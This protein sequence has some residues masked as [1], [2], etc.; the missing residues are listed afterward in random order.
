MAYLDR[1]KNL[2]VIRIVLDGPPE[3]GKATTLRAL[4]H[5]LRQTG[6][7][8]RQMG[9]RA[10]HVDWL[11]HSSGRTIRLLV[12]RAPRG[13]MRLRHRRV[14]AA[15]VVVYVTPATEA[16]L[17]R[18]LRKLRRMEND[19]AACGGAPPPTIVQ[20]N[21]RDQPD[22]MT[23]E[24]LRHALA[25][26]GLPY[27][28]VETVATS[29]DGVH[30]MFLLAVKFALARAQR[31]MR[32]DRPSDPRES[33]AF[34]VVP[35]WHG[36][37]SAPAPMTSSSD[38][39][40]QPRTPRLP[41]MSRIPSG[42]VWP[43]IEGR[44]CLEDMFGETTAFEPHADGWLG[45]M[46]S[47]SQPD[48]SWWLLA[49]RE[50]WFPTLADGRSALV[51][52]ARWFYSHRGTLS[53]GRTVL[54][55]EDHGGGWR[56]WQT[57]R[58]HPTLRDR[59]DAHGDETKPEVLAKLIV[60]IAASLLHLDRR[61]TRLGERRLP[62]SIDTVGIVGGTPMFVGLVPSSDAGDRLSA[63]DL[64]SFLE[65]F[66]QNTRAICSD[67]ADTLQSFAAEPGQSGTGL[68]RRLATMLRAPR[69]HPS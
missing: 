56:L 40:S 68:G 1:T 63:P 36:G 20:L 52:H 35:E 27:E 61:L 32:P 34:G 23:N 29:G 31:L 57:A 37:G 33:D 46:S 51:R 44:S 6:V 7:P 16:S 14:S 48:R 53:T 11:D 54:L 9:K 60:E 17:T 26:I 21:K 39:S 19:L 3:S 43:P 41:N 64:L 69:R 2:V 22:S 59:L 12:V 24:Q 4:T 18:T 49:W 13:P 8:L 25:T 67:I 15:D 55:A 10:I 45:S 65:S 30:E 38:G 28:V 42:C 47:V 50:A 62:L 5:A 58:R 66:R